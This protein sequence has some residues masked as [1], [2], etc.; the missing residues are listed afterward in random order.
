MRVGDPPRGRFLDRGLD[1]RLDVAEHRLVFSKPAR[2]DLRP[3]GDAAG[4]G[5]DGHNDRDEAFVAQNA[6]VFEQRF[7]RGPDARPVNVDVPAFDSTSDRRPALE[8]E[9]GTERRFLP[10]FVHLGTIEVFGG[11]WRELGLAIQAAPYDAIVDAGRIGSRG[12]PGGLVETASRV[13]V[14][15]RSSLTSLAALRL[16]LG[17][18]LEQVPA[19]QVGLVIVGPGR[20][21]SAKEA[22]EQFGVSVL[23]EIAWDASGASDLADGQPLSKRWRQ[24][25][26]ASSYAAA[27][28]SLT[29]L[30]ETERLR[31]GAPS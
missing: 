15:C 25:R 20:P 2:Q 3:G 26:L 22:A 11:V 21:Y 8:R 28:R 18:L 6:P 17:P 12:L 23:A 5:V 9:R 31:I 27:A 7:V 30:H 10:G 19:E 24:G 4:R 1:G 13:G 14:V 29:A 16:Y